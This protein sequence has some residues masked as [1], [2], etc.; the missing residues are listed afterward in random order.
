MI[1]NLTMIYQGNRL[2]KADDATGNTKGFI[3]GVKV[4]KEYFYDANGNLTEYLNKNITAIQYNYLNLP[5]Y[6]TN[7]KRHE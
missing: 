7:T 6:Q 4:D 5:K 1:D 2:I 3:D